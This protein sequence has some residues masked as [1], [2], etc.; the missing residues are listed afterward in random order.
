MKNRILN[1]TPHTINL[2]G[3]GDVNK[4]Y[5]SFYVKPGARARRVLPSCGMA[6]VCQSSEPVGDVDGVPCYKLRDEMIMGLP[7][8]EEGRWLVVSY[9]TLVAAKNIGRPTDDL[10]VP[11]QTVRDSGGR[12]L[13]C[14]SFAGPTV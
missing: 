3:P 14:I 4:V 13:G 5:D 6:R 7:K 10:L 12:V 11:F 2:Y 9:I 1:L 8:P